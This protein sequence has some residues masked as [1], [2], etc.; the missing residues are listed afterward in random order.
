MR[1]YFLDCDPQVFENETAAA[2]GLAMMIAEASSKAIAE[3]GIF[4]IAVSGKETTAALSQLG[5]AVKV[6]AHACFMA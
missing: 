5:A 4:T 6:C 3:R 1:N 2:G